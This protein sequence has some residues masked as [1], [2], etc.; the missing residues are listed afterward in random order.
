MLHPVARE[1]WTLAVEELWPRGLRKVDL[2]ELRMLCEQAAVVWEAANGRAG[3]ARIGVIIPD[4]RGDRPDPSDPTKVIHTAFL[5]NPTV[6]IG[7]DATNTF[8]RMAQ[9]F[10]FDIASRMRLGLMQLSGQ[11]L[12]DALMDELERD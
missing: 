4:P 6:R 2:M 5:P 8:I 10:G 7:R 9:A 1:S 12:A 11:S 3:W